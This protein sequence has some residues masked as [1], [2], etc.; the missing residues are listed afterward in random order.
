MDIKTKQIRENERLSHT[1]IY[2]KEEAL[3]YVGKWKE[4]FFVNGRG[5][6]KWN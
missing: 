6:V 4:G 2:T 5:S 1:E 3:N